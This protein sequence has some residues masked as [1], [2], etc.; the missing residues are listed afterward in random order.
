MATDMATMV[1]VIPN[2]PLKLQ[3]EIMQG[4]FIDL[5]EL[6][7][8][9]FRFEYASVDSNGAFKL[10]YKDETVIMWPREKVKQIA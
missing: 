10:V 6:L 2:V 4:E 7:Q 3:Q 5:S 8:P 9:D 1:K